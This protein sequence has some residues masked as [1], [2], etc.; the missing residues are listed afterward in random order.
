MAN[1]SNVKSRTGRELCLVVSGGTEGYR[2][3][4]DGTWRVT[5]DGR[6]IP[7]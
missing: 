5:L 1:E 7:G 2:G 6:E 3:L 4:Q